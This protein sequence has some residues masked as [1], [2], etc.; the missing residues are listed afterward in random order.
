MGN[1]AVR[2]ANERIAEKAHELGFGDEDV[3]PFLCECANQP[4]LKIVRLP[5]REFERR[6]VTPG[7]SVTLAG[8]AAEAA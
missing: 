4:C 7:Q 6:C 1:G 2:A 8:H 3:M 5:I